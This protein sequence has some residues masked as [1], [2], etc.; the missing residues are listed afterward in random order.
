MATRRPIS[1][2]R[3][4]ELLVGLSPPLRL[5]RYLFF[6]IIAL[7]CA[8]KVPPPQ[9]PDPKESVAINVARAFKVDRP[10]ATRDLTELTRV[11]HVFGTDRQ[12]ELAQWLTKSLQA[13][14][15]KAEVEEFTAEVPASITN[16]GIGVSQL[17]EKVTGRNVV[18]TL[19]PANQD[20]GRAPACVIA[21]ASHFDSKKISNGDYVGANDSGSSTALLLQIMAYL[22]RSQESTKLPCSFVALFFDGEEAVLPNWFDGQYQH[23]ARIID[24]TYGSR[25]SASR[26]DRCSSKSQTQLCM[27]LDPLWGTTK[28][29][30]PQ[31]E[32]L[33]L[34][35]MVG[36]PDLKLTRESESTP[37]LMQDALRGATLLGQPS[38]FD[39]VPNKVEDDHTAF[40]ERGVNALDIIDF[41]HLQHWHQPSDTAAT[42]SLDSLELAGRVAIFAAAKANLRH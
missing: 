9:A 1:G 29:T 32:G 10:R 22:Q 27:P 34:L 40:L 30:G 39:S 7:A 35:D 31:L 24:H 21:L 17:T 28:G 2:G 33:V 18:A 25:Y 11:P 13:D 16:A 36:T 15:L 12:K 26:L 14:G 41:T 19:K 4:S 42:V 37:A 20:S 5:G 3:N 6:P 8:T 38:L 23:P